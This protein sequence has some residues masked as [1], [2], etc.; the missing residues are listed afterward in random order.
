MAKVSRYETNKGVKWRVRYTTRD[1]RDTEKSGFT[2]KRDAEAWLADY[3]VARRNGTLVDERAR[4]VLLGPL[5]EKHLKQLSHLAPTTASNRRSIA[6]NW[7]MPDWAT[8]R[9]GDVRPSDV[10]DW[11]ERLQ[12]EPRSVKKG[13]GHVTKTA[14]APTI[15]KAHGILLQVFSAAVDDE[16]LVKNPASGVK[17]PRQPKSANKYLRMSELIELADAADPRY[18]LLILTLGLTGMR[19]SEAVALKKETVW[20]DRRRFRLEKAVVENK[21]KL[22]WKDLK[23]YKLRSVPIPEPIFDEIASRVA[24]LRPEGQLFVAPRSEVLRLNTW[25]DRFFYTAIEEVDRRRREAAGGGRFDRF[26]RVTPHDLRHTAASMAVS[27]GANVKV[28]QLML[29]H[30]SAKM[31]LDQYADLFD[32]DLDSVA[33]L[34]AA[35]YRQN[36]TDNA[37]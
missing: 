12:T 13:A 26:P 10:R 32:E 17:L 11:V 3:N 31:T 7:V 8:W 5:I 33:N 9:I 20:L 6:Q 15:E 29:G 2:T 22:V 27:A 19:Y 35:M 14:G 23:G 37:A 18:R 36:T 16:V 34:M 24:V 4:K 25:R 28:L 30:Q 21:G 1:G